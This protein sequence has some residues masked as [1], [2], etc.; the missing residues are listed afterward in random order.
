MTE[1]RA[2]RSGPL[3]GVKVVELGG[4]GPCPFAGMTLADLGAEVV[5]IDRPGG[6]AIV[7]G[8]P[9]YDVLNRGKRSVALNLKRPEAVK[10]VLAMVEKAD[11]MLE[12]FRPGVAERFGLSPEECWARNPRLVYGRMTGWGQTGPLS[13]AAG[14]DIN[15][16][17]LTGALHAIGNADGPPQVPVNFIGDFG[18][19]G[20]YLVIGVLAALREVEKAGHGQVVDA[21]IVDGASHLLAGI[22]GLLN[23]GAWTDERGVN[24]LDGAAP[25]YAVYETADRRHMAVGAIESKFYSELLAKLGI[26][27]NPSRQHDRDT[28]PATSK[29]IADVFRSR[30]QAEWVAV[31][32]GSDACV[33][34]VL[35][36]RE[37]A[38]NPHIRARSSVVARDGLLQPAPAP[39]FSRSP[40]AIGT[41]PPVVGEHTREAL[42]SWG[43]ADFDEL[44]ANGAA[45]EAEE[46]TRS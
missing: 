19:G 31:F 25:F 34:P 36:L 5:L 11:V 6:N 29:R 14:H 23:A 27:E 18:G 43:V 37:A 33:A 12:G 9:R 41:P 39:R 17:A 32:F 20:T 10:A 46:G 30:T 16:I 38:E 28:W 3:T 21:A 35:S 44:I 22:H 45:V 15:Y 4:M 8:D 13:S 1:T 24:F 7:P 2:E 26:D 42:E 40:T